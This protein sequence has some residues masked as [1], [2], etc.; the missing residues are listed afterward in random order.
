MKD[1]LGSFIYLFTYSFIFPE[2]QRQ[3][4][5]RGQDLVSEAKWLGFEL[6]H[7]LTA[8]KGRG[9]GVGGGEID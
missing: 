1:L 2:E 5:F 4:I 6:S 9:V 3:D 7:S 8:L